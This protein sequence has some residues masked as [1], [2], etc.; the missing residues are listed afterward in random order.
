MRSVITRETKRSVRGR[1]WQSFAAHTALCL[2]YPDGKKNQHDRETVDND[3]HDHDNGIGDED[4]DN[5]TFKE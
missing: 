4:Y 2:R 1:R 3:D 5:G